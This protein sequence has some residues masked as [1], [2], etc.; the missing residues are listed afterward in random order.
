MSLLYV[1]IY[2]SYLQSGIS[3]ELCCLLMPSSLVEGA[4][5]GEDAI[6][7]GINTLVSILKH[8]VLSETVLHTSQKFLAM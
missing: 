3:G 8:L 7:L 1:S 2:E 5:Q 4:G 6:C